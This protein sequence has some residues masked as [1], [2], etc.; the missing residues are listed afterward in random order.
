MGTECELT[1]VFPSGKSHLIERTLQRAEAALREVEVRMST[2]ISAAELSR[3]NAAAAGEV[4][5]LS[6]A[7]M[8]VLRISRK[9]AT[10]TQGAFDVTCRPILQVWV[11]TRGTGR[12]PT[13][14]ELTEAKNRTGWEHFELVEGGARKDID[15]AGIDLGGIAK[16]YAIDLALTAMMEAHASGGLVNVG[17]DVRCFG[18]RTDGQPWCIGVRDPFDNALIATLKIR[19]KA[20]CTSGNYQRFI[21]I[22]GERYSH[23]VDPRTALPVEMTPSV[24]TIAPTA[25]IADAWATALSVLGT[26]GLRLIPGHSGIEAAIIIGTP[27]KYEIRVTDGFERFFDERPEAKVTIHRPSNGPT[28]T[29]QVK[30]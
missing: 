7:T 1:V 3:L 14:P 9:L 29:T 24:T 27:E 10:Q 28:A 25:A 12:S 23:I 4:V 18:T 22:D 5:E 2:Y 30:D 11:G 20:V 6:P 16:G 21:E 17:G 8:E 15:G 26:E 19:D 13:H